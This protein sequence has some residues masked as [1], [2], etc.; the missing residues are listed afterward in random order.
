M[1]VIFDLFCDINDSGTNY[2]MIIDYPYT[3]IESRILP[4]LLDMD[5][6]GSA[7]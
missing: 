2:I 3:N 1:G 6:K 7:Y 4:P 5:N